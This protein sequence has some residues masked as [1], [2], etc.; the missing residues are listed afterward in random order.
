MSLKKQQQLASFS[1]D[2]AAFLEF[3]A[4]RRQKNYLR[5]WSMTYL[6]PPA[7]LT[8]SR[9]LCEESIVVL[10]GGASA[11]LSQ[12]ITVRGRKRIFPLCVDLVN[13]FYCTG[14]PAT[15]VPRGFSPKFP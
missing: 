6:R 15:R 14:P 9:G 5:T 7:S 8:A 1:C 12:K 2:D 4:N 3:R 11:E 13:I 10:E